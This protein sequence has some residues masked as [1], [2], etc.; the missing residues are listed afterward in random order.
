V[1]ALLILIGVSVFIT[2]SPVV[3]AALSALFTGG[4]MFDETSS[5]VYL[6]YL[7]VSIPLGVTTLIIG[8]IVLGI[9]YLA[10]RK[11]SGTTTP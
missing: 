3:L 1:L 7:F 5:G 9:R 6:W 8:L 2:I 10:H 11:R 4:R